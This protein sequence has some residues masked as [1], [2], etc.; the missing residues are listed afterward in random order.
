MSMLVDEHKLDRYPF[1]HPSGKFF[2]RFRFDPS[3]ILDI[4]TFHATAP[5]SKYKNGRGQILAIWDSKQLGN[6]V[7][8]VKPNHHRLKK[9]PPPD[10]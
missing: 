10:T 3:P 8:L 2:M 6:F 9:I 4:I 7:G 5:S 1:P